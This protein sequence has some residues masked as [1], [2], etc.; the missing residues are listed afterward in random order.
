MRNFHSI[1]F[2]WTRTY[3]EIFKSTLVY[4]YS[5][6]LISSFWFLVHFYYSL[7][8]RRCWF[9]SMRKYQIYL[10]KPDIVISNSIE[11]HSKYWLYDQT[12]NMNKQSWTCSL[13][14]LYYFPTKRHVAL[15][16]SFYKIYCNI[17]S[18][19]FGRNR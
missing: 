4:R 11:N 1:I 17:Y 16:K 13:I 19:L 5:S 8:W 14:W 6:W 9:E 2:I 3:S 12:A 10:V 15:R 7:L 18:F